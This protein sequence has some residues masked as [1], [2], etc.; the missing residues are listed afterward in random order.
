[1]TTIAEQV[2]TQKEIKLKNGVI[3]PG[4]I[5]LSP[6]DLAKLEE[7][8]ESLP[9]EEIEGLLRAQRLSQQ[10]REEEELKRMFRESSRSSDISCIEYSKN[11]LYSMQ[12]RSS[13]YQKRKAERNFKKKAIEDLIKN[14]PHLPGWWREILKKKKEYNLPK[15]GDKEKAISKAKRFFKWEK[16]EWTLGAWWSRVPIEALWEFAFAATEKYACDRNP[17]YFIKCLATAATLFSRYPNPRVWHEV[18]Q[19]LGPYFKLS[20]ERLLTLLEAVTKALKQVPKAG[21]M[22]SDLIRKFLPVPK[23]RDVEMFKPGWD[24]S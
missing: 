19:R 3:V 15:I 9:P 18:S 13:Y 23:R 24:T 21:E 1:M 11:K 22:L 14:L 5:K 16:G 7:L 4:D 8:S 17:V 2:T 10:K 20:R 12:K 6:Q